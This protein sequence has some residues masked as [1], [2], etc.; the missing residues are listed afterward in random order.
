MT[1]NYKDTYMELLAWKW[2]RVSYFYNHNILVTIYWVSTIWRASL[3]AQR[4]KRL[5][6][7][8]ETQIQ[9]LGREEPLEKE[10]ATHSSILAW[11]ISWTEEPGRLQSMG[12][13]RVGHNWATS[14]SLMYILKSLYLSFRE[15]LDFLKSKRACFKC[16]LFQL[17]AM[18]SWANYFLFSSL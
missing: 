15:K 7:R 13:L 18:W 1:K 6:A 9:S 8:R 5:P 11:R 12:S 17:L 10:M 4:V 14:L 2:F 16:R 3:V